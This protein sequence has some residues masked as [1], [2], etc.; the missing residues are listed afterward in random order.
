[1]TSTEEIRGWLNGSLGNKPENATH[2]IVVCDTF[3]WDDYP[4]YGC[5]PEEVW[6]KIDNP[7]EMQRVMEVYDFNAPLEPQLKVFRANYPPDRPKFHPMTGSV[8][9]VLD[10]YKRH[11]NQFP[12]STAYSR[13]DMIRDIR[14]AYEREQRGK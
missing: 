8:D 12:Y 7:G 3:D 13:H 2:M 10:G 4:V 11:Y 1:M 9:Q 5:S 14:V 6:D